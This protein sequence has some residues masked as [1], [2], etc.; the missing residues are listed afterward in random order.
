MANSEP[1]PV[2][3]SEDQQESQKQDDMQDMDID[4]FDMKPMTTG[5]APSQPAQKVTTG[6]DDLDIFGGPAPQLQTNVSAPGVQAP[7]GPEDIFSGDLLG[8]GNNLNPPISQATQPQVPQ[9]QVSNDLYD[10]D[11]FGG[12]TQKQEPQV[13]VP[14]QNPSQNIGGFDLM[15]GDMLGGSNP[16]TNQPKV[17]SSPQNDGF[18]FDDFEDDKKKTADDPNALKFTAFTTEHLDV[19]FVSKKETEN[20]TVVHSV[21]ANKTTNFISDLSVKVAAAKH[22]KMNLMSLNKD[23]IDPN[24]D[25][26]TSQTIEIENSM[27]G[28]K[29]VA[30]KIKISYKI[31]GVDFNKEGIIQG[32]PS[33]Y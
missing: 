17:P 3:G 20:K 10:M 16:T 29:A 14:Q 6:L 22:L 15:G 27:Q 33:D 24:N 4:I 21:Y 32:F 11:L 13:P 19:K 9:Q 12:M 18:E 30:L 8:G 23:S 2:K 26:E 31:N 1:T 28:K 25:G 5:T 7:S